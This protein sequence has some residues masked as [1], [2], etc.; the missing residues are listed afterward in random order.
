[1]MDFALWCL[2]TAISTCVVLA[3]LQRYRARLRD[4][5]GPTGL[6]IIGNLH[7]VRVNAA[8]KYRTWAE[9]HGP[10]YQIMLGNV[11][12]IV[13]NSAQAAREIFVANSSA[14]AGRPEFYTFHKV[15]SSTSGTTVGTSPFNESLRRRRKGIA[16]ALNKSSVESY[17]PHMDLETRDF[18]K[19]LFRYGAGGR[20]PIDP[21]P[22][23][24]RL[25]LSLALTMNW[26]TR[27][28]S[29][30]D[31]L[32]DEITFVEEEIT[33]FRS[34][35]GNLQ[36]YIP[37]LRLNPINFSSAS[38]KDMR[39]RRDVYLQKLNR[40]L[41]A[42]MAKGIYQSCIQ[43]NVILNKD[44]KLN[45]E[46]LTSISL[47]ML[48]GGLD[49]LTTVVVWAIALLARRPD[50]QDQA[51]R[52]IREV[53]SAHQILC[54]AHNDQAIP[55]VSALA[56]EFL[57]YFT[58]VRLSLPRSAVKDVVY[59]DKLIPA[60]TVVFLNAWA[61]NMDPEIWH[62]PWVFRPER[63]LEH[64]EAPLFSYGLGYRACTGTLLANGELYLIFLR[65]ITAF[66]VR[67]AVGVDGE[68][69]DIHPVRGVVDQRLIVS[70]PRRYRVKIVPRDEEKLGEALGVV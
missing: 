67:D 37:L 57:R 8:A 61:C 69:V 33:R 1:M 25:S 68:E 42:R 27:M 11:P 30:E 48:S 70:M 39:R 56:R 40:D 36:D 28:P 9:K 41:E 22:L 44:N 3:E 35:T 18:I 60:G 14:L 65:L 6:P 31:A 12:V 26:G 51:Y 46:E 50:I 32:F 59:Q 15:V 23:I 34:T 2:L 43:G 10:V 55:Y 24:Q 54:D 58:P 7:Q 13:V 66:E 16:S 47:S 53:Y 20:N 62:D 63:W 21:V 29:Q 19:D 49:T 4:W 17:V 38:A 52:N 5:K 45:A 64:P